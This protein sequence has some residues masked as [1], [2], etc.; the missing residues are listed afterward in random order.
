[1]TT[2]QNKVICSKDKYKTSVRAWIAASNVLRKPSRGIDALRVY[3]CEK[4]K[5]FH[6]TKQI[7]VSESVKK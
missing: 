5:A 1:M 6:L 7:V 2:R 3:Y 4:C